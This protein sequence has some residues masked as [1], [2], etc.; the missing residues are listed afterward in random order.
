M[1]QS[2]SKN[3]PAFEPRVECSDRIFPHNEPLLA[4]V[5]E[6]I[7]LQSRSS[8]YTVLPGEVREMIFRLSMIDTLV[9]ESSK[10]SSHKTASTVSHLNTRYPQ[11][12]HKSPS[13]NSSLALLLTCRRT[14]LETYH[15]PI[16]VKEHLFYLPSLIGPPGTRNLSIEKYLQRFK[17]QQLRFLTDVHIFIH[18]LFLEDGSF[19]AICKRG[20]LQGIRKLKITI[21]YRDWWEWETSLKI[22]MSPWGRCLEY[23]RPDGTRQVHS[24]SLKEHAWGYAFQHLKGLEELELQLESLGDKFD[25]LEGVVC[26]AREWA[27]PI[28]GDR[29]LTNRGS[30]ARVIWECLDCTWSS[31]CGRCVG[32]GDNCKGCVRRQIHRD[33]CLGPIINTAVLRWRIGSGSSSRAV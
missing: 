21:R 19:T 13:S 7:N 3:A 16:Q 17:P 12:R 5:L 8:L 20:L 26:E 18:Q 9:S 10:K 31:I 15:L 24:V 29:L 28:S 14:Y 23:R 4:S 22:E 6:E 30:L 33:V 32:K 1:G 25:E 2:A 11:S 27:F